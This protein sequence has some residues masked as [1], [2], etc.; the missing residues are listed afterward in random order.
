[1]NINATKLRTTHLDLTTT[2]LRSGSLNR[3]YP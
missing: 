1:L 3:N 2:S